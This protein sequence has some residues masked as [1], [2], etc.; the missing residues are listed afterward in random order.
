[1]P[2]QEHTHSHDHSLPKA[3]LFIL[4]RARLIDPTGTT[5]I[6][7]TFA[8]EMRIR[9]ELLRREILRAVIEDDVF[10]LEDL[11]NSEVVANQSPGYKAYQFQTDDQKI[12]SFL[13]WLNQETEDKV[14]ASRDVGLRRT[15]SQVFTSFDGGWTD[16]YIDSSYQKG[17]R[18]AR[19]NLA[20]K[21][22]AQDTSEIG[23]S[24][25]GAFTETFNTPVHIQRVSVL[26][27]RTFE[28]LKGVTADMSRDMS[29]ILS[30]GLIEG[31]GPREIGRSLASVIDK[32]YPAGSLDLVDAKGRFIPSK[33]RAEMIARTEVIRAH[34]LGNIQE[35]KA[36]GV[37]KVGVQAEWITAGDDRV[38]SKCLDME[39]GGPY[40][41][42]E[43]ESLIPLHPNC[44][45]VA[46]PLSVKPQGQLGADTLA[47]EPTG[48]LPSE[49]LRTPRSRNRDRLRAARRTKKERTVET[50]TELIEEGTRTRKQLIDDAFTKMNGDVA[51]PTIGVQLQKVGEESVALGRFGRR[52]EIDPNT[53]VIRFT[54]TKPKPV[55]PKPR[56]EPVK[57]DPIPPSSTIPQ[58]LFENPRIKDLRPTKPEHIARIKA[59]LKTKGLSRKDKAYFRQ[60][61]KDADEGI[62][63]PF[64]PN[65]PPAHTAQKISDLRIRNTRGRV[66]STNVDEE[67]MASA[68]IARAEDYRELLPANEYYTTQQVKELS[69]AIAGQVR[70]F[71]ELR[72]VKGESIPWMSSKQALKD[73]DNAIL[74]RD[75]VKFVKTDSGQ[76]LYGRGYTH[77]IDNGD[78]FTRCL[79]NSGEGDYNDI[80]QAVSRLAAP[81]QTAAH[82]VFARVSDDVAA[83][84]GYKR[85]AVEI[86]KA[87]KAQETVADFV[88]RSDP[89]KEYVISVGRKAADDATDHILYVRGGDFFADSWDSSHSFVKVVRERPS[90]HSIGAK[91][92]EKLKRPPST[93]APTA[94]QIK[95][96]TG[97]TGS[98]VRDSR[99][100]SS[101]PKSVDKDS[102]FDKK[103]SLDVIQSRASKA[104]DATFKASIQKAHRKLKGYRSEQQL[105]KS[106]QLYFGID[107]NTV[108]FNLRNHVKLTDKWAKKIKDIKRDMRPLNDDLVVFRGLKETTLSKKA[109]EKFMKMNVGDEFVEDAFT[110]TSR[111]YGT[112]TE[113]FTSSLPVQRLEDVR[114]AGIVFEIQAKKGTRAIISNYSEAEVIL[115]AGTRFRVIEILEKPLLKGEVKKVWDKDLKKFVFKSDY[116]QFRRVIRLEVVD[117]AAVRVPTP[118]IPKVRPKPKP[119]PKSKLTG[120]VKTKKE[121]AVDELR[122]LI[123][124][125]SRT[126]KQLID[127]VFDALDGQVAKPTIGVQLQKID[128]E[129]VALARFGRRI[130]VD[131]KTKVVSYTDDV[132]PPVPKPT[133]KPK[134]E[135][136]TKPDI[137][138]EVLAERKRAEK[139]L[140]DLNL[141]QLDKDGLDKV[142]RQWAD[143]IGE[144]FDTLTPEKVAEIFKRDIGKDFIPAFNEAIED[145]SVYMAIKNANLNKVIKENK[146]KN[147]LETGKG[148]FKTI[149]KDRF[150]KREKPLWGLSDDVLDDA[151]LAPK[152]GFLAGKEEMDY[153]RIVDWGYGEN[154]VKFKPGIK[155]RS[156][157]TAGDSFD[158]N[159]FGK[160]AR[161]IRFDKPDVLG[162]ADDL[163]PFTYAEGIDRKVLQIGSGVKKKNYKNLVVSKNYQDI[164]KNRSTYLEVQ[165]FG[166]VNLDDVA[167]IFVTSKKY[168]KTLERSLK[169]AGY[170]HIKVRAARYDARLKSLWEKHLS[171]LQ[172]L[173]PTDVDRLGD[174]W[175][176]KLWDHW[177]I[178]PSSRIGPTDV[179]EKLRSRVAALKRGSEFTLKEKRA[180]MRDWQE[181]LW[182]MKKNKDN[183]F[184][185][186]GA[187]VDMK[188][189]LSNFTDDVFNEDRLKAYLTPKEFIESNIR[190]VESNLGSSEFFVKK[191]GDEVRTASNPSDKAKAQELLKK[192]IETRDKDKIELDGL[193]RQLKTLED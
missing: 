40:L 110:S 156:T 91:F 65:P 184:S 61:L 94:K 95:A 43:I 49:V 28:T 148:T 55:A 15:S 179:P 99:V 80:F 150:E 139:F 142:T 173:S 20:K 13:D 107:Y 68:W 67:N 111:S 124:D 35:L 82:G 183:R 76:S 165:M 46:I 190:R 146:F 1:M 60:L 181:E 87:R 41:L 48:G 101:G 112:V 22:L 12:N 191:Y 79:V 24:R 47:P 130:K 182:A 44:R 74:K 133:P 25:R 147:S 54:G 178:H 6:R 5:K 81:N 64:S 144:D 17:I 89:T 106:T 167:E 9:F 34:H 192:S 177:S 132:T 161:P 151:D 180:F 121:L 78:C 115:D 108:N 102:I 186:K 26:F 52:I 188:S 29:Q 185:W 131:P 93:P 176:E 118:I 100:R 120:P 36:F 27:T 128:D 83:H 145:T 122:E 170:G 62:A 4:N 72:I 175:I 149:A 159:S 98:R 8:R 114:E 53:K 153:E 75:G 103:L 137:P 105:S 2:L 141:D 37:D 140:D 11:T 155:K 63:I 119:T 45:C 166:K 3:D 77:M 135:P 164:V 104:E 50:L 7:D 157:W 58:E 96:R 59:K 51:K 18:D 163:N 30:Q 189:S 169:K 14:F 21:G 92:T 88:R 33:R 86:N 84:F 109:R 143:S 116:R 123:K 97:A 134:P 125:G 174:Q 38:C 171:N 162:L 70:A 19:K 39:S 71:K 56:P 152:Y 16:Q 129:A 136:V 73:I 127:D 172:S 158:N 117:D 31:K 113:S 42:T 69:E 154:F 85:S 57:A 23:R 126:R 193:K 138:E 187:T 10:G 160:T 66:L 32:K 168:A 90:R